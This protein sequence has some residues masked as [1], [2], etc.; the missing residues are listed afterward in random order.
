[1]SWLLARQIVAKSE[2]RNE[3]TGFSQMFNE[4]HAP[5]FFCAVHGTSSGQHNG[6]RQ[7]PASSNRYLL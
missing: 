2:W 4:R 5:A 1:M 3:E 6:R 7:L